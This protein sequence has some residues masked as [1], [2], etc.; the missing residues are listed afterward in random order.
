MMAAELRM[1]KDTSAEEK[2]AYVDAIIARLGL[3][4]VGRLGA[5][6]SVYNSVEEG[7]RGWKG[8]V[9][10]RHHRPPGPGKGRQH[11]CLDGWGGGV[12]CGWGAA[13]AWVWQSGGGCKAE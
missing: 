11:A 3:A 1:S 10:G 13:H 4:K 8:G 2:D 7:V 9:C 12:V 5:F 6:M